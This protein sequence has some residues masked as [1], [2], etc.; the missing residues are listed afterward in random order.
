MDVST[1]L[2]QSKRNK[3]MIILT[4][5]LVISAMNTT[6]FN[7]AL[8]AIGEQFSLSPS[9]T[10][11]IV[12]SYLIIFAVGVTIYGKLADQYKLKTLITT[13]IILMALGSLIGLLALNYPLLV[14]ARVIQAAGAAVLPALA[15]IIPTRYFTPET[16]GRAIGMTSAGLTFGIAIGPIIAGLI[17]TSFSWNKLFIIP[18][19]MVLSIPIFR[20]YLGDEKG[21]QSKID[22]IGALLLVA[23]IVSFM[24]V[25]S[26]SSWILFILFV[27]FLGAFIWRIKTTK[28]PFIHPGLFKN[29]SYTFTLLT[30]ALGA[31]AA[32]S[33]PYLSPLL[34]VNV[35]HLSPFASG[36]FMFPGA[37]IAALLAKTGGKIADTRGNATLAYMTILLFLICFGL[38]SF[39]AGASAYL[40]MVIL[41]LGYVAQSQWQVAMANTLSNT[42]S[43]EQVGIGMGLFMLV[44]FVASSIAGTFIGRALSSRSSFSLNPW[45]NQASGGEYSNIY[46]VLSVVIIITAILYTVVLRTTKNKKSN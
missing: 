45:H 19:V 24:L 12:T 2:A 44:N 4:S 8:P 6:M 26:Q 9:Q 11:W 15:M 1:S 28:N 41:I 36:L 30:F 38:L 14:I 33:L 32:F 34:F 27:I 22:F 25:I 40:V 42:L 16:R 7:V 29:K 31:G 46:V 17:L 3:L 21:T 35:N 18:L 10:G 13:G 23:T 37:L 20:K 39:F 43:K 5:V